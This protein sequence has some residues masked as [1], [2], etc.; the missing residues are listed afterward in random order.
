MHPIEIGNGYGYFC[1]LDKPKKL[2]THK[3]FYI[4]DIEPDLYSTR[5]TYHINI[6]TNTIPMSN[7]IKNNPTI[8]LT[9]PPAE[10]VYREL[11]CESINIKNTNKECKTAKISGREAVGDRENSGERSSKEFGINIVQFY[12]IFIT[13]MLIYT[14]FIT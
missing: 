7:K 4:D 12:G 8:I 14:L 3:R 9:T 13:T 6:Y 10:S 5:E 11:D 2:Y 1:D